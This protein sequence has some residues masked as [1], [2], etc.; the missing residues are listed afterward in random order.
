MDGKW[1]NCDAPLPG[2]PKLK[3][4][5]RDFKDTHPDMERDMMPEDSTPAS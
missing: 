4:T 1:Q 5:I 2:P 3:V